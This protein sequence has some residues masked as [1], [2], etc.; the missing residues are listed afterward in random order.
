MYFIIKDNKKEGPFTLDEMLNLMLTDET[1]IWKDG[2]SDWSKISDF[3]ELKYFIIK[4]PPPFPNLINNCETKEFHTQ[5]VAYTR[6]IFIRSTIIGF[7]L[8]IILDLI[9]TAY[10]LS[11]GTNEYHIFLTYEERNNP[12]NLFFEFF[13]YCIILGEM[14]PLLL[15]IW[16]IIV[17]KPH[18][19]FQDKS[20]V[21]DF[22]LSNINKISSQPKSQHIPYEMSEQ[23]KNFLFGI[24]FTILIFL[25]CLLI[26]IYT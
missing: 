1:L 25:I 18:S 5:R 24:G 23:T 6:K 19:N 10:A 2:K 9:V 16:K 13:P 22:S 7:I 17:Y 11:G 21:S 12:L 3:P 8:G 26:E 4:T 14:F 15:A 20:K